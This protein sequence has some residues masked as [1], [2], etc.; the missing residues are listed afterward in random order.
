MHLLDYILH[1]RL[2]HEYRL[3][4]FKK[5]VKISKAGT[6]AQREALKAITPILDK[7][8]IKLGKE[9]ADLALPIIRELRNVLLSK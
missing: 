1:F 8:I 2:I 6:A 7:V 3:Y 5:Q 4:L 9:K